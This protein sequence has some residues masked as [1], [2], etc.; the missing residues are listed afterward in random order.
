[1]R[2][3]VRGRV[4]FG[5]GA[6]RG[7]GSIEV[8]GIVVRSALGG[9]AEAVGLAGERTLRPEDFGR[10]A[11]DEAKTLLKTLQP[12]WTTYWNLRRKETA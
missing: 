2:D 11:S 1:L 10:N 7:L 12:D 4:P 9:L 8:E 5:F 6:N 3:V